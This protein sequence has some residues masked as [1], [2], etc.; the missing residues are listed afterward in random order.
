MVNLSHFFLILFSLFVEGHFAQVN[1]ILHLVPIHLEL[2]NLLLSINEHTAHL[3]L[4]MDHFR[5]RSLQAIYLKVNE[6]LTLL[7]LGLV[8]LQ[9]EVVGFVV[10]E[11]ESPERLIVQT[12]VDEGFLR[13]VSFDNL[14]LLL[15]E[16]ELGELSFL[17]SLLRELDPST[18]LLLSIGELFSLFL[19]LTHLSD[20]RLSLLLERVDSTSLGFSVTL[21]LVLGLR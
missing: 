13:P 10:A 7:L 16:F 18:A 8:G 20:L 1:N 5:D 17:V 9:I 14:E 4:R 15:E 19:D 21:S 12:H 3:L 2:L 11:H 6:Q